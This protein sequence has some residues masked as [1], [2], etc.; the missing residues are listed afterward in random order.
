MLFL[1][2]DSRR[3]RCR[4][5]TLLY[6]PGGLTGS[7]TLKPPLEANDLPFGLGRNAPVFWCE[8]HPTR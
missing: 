4:L 8:L 3:R 1:F 7:Q 6:T 5:F 2:L